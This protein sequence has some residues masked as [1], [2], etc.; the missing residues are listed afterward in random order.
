MLLLYYI[1]HTLRILSYESRGQFKPCCLAEFN[2]FTLPHKCEVECRD[3]QSLGPDSNW[4][5]VSCCFEP[6]KEMMVNLQSNPG[7]LIL[8]LMYLSCTSHVPPMRL[9]CPSRWGPMD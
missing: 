5:N 8:L 2:T 7:K 4:Y 1:V 3:C 9:S 6:V